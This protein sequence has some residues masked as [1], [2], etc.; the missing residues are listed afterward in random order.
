[1]IF[2]IPLICVATPRWR[3]GR[4]AANGAGDAAAPAATPGATA[5][6]VGGAGALARVDAE[7]PCT[8]AAR[9]WSR[10]HAR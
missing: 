6:A 9:R 1:M 5:S 8:L 2:V 4:A 7:C 10:N 3:L